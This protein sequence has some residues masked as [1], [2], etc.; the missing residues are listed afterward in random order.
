MLM[1]MRGGY[2]TEPT[3]EDVNAIKK[4]LMMTPAERKNIE[5][6]VEQKR[7]EKAEREQKRRR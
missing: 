2:I 1:I 5:R 6:Q 3:K 4:W 7:K